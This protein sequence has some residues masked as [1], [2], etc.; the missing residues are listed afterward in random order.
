MKIAPVW[1]ILA[2]TIVAYFLFYQ[3]LDLIYFKTRSNKIIREIESRGGYL[4]EQI[5][6]KKEGCDPF[7][8]N[9]IKLA[10]NKKGGSYSLF[11]HHW[12]CS[13]TTEKVRWQCKSQI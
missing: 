5:Y 4:S 13:K 10:Y 6:F 11:V 12:I 8:T 2:I 7:G 1:S 9:C 3:H